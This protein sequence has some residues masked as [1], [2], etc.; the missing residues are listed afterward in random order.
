MRNCRQINFGTKDNIMFYSFIIN[1]EFV[2]NFIKPFYW[3]I[4]DYKNV[5]IL[6]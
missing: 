5:A 2:E 1:N 3:L 6:K 4:L